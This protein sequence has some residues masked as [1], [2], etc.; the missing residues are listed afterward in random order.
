MDF[1]TTHDAP[2]VVTID[3]TAYHVP[4]FL[5]GALKRW[6]AEARKEREDAALAEFGDDAETRA[7]FRLVMPDPPVDIA[8]LLA[9]VRS[10]DGAERVVRAQFALAG[11][12]AE[13]IDKV[14]AQA[15][16]M[17]LR[18]LADELSMA[19]PAEARLGVKEEES[20]DPLPGGRG[21]PDD[22]P[23][24]TPGTS[25]GSAPPTPASTPTA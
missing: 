5:L 15:E 14:V 23:G 1:F 25:P 19:A 16:P 4:R 8:D 6:A 17:L 9:R 10:P 7:R 18:R 2:F 20:A 22:S 13:T 21:A 3:G 11:V 12:P 24:T